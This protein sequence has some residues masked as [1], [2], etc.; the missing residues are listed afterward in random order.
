MTMCKIVLNGVLGLKYSCRIFIGSLSQTSSGDLFKP[1]LRMHLRRIGAA[2]RRF[3]LSEIKNKHKMTICNIVLNR[4]PG[5]RR[6]PDSSD[7]ALYSGRFCTWQFFVFLPT[8]DLRER[9]S[10]MVSDHVKQRTS[11]ANIVR[12]FQTKRP[13]QDDFA[14]S[15]FAPVFYRYRSSEEGLG[16]R[17]L[18]I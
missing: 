17:H 16:R 6:S 15:Y 8:G 13:I 11:D 3:R 12:A 10:T 7:Q 2:N 9:P 14:H 4:A 1:F 18:T 5:L